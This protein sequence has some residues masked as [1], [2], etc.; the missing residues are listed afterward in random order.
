MRVSMGFAVPEDKI[1]EVEANLREHGYILEPD[2]VWRHPDRRDD[3]IP[4]F[5]QLVK[6][7]CDG[8]CHDDIIDEAEAADL[9]REQEEF[10]GN[11][12]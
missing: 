4:E 11:R 6:A 3:A 10:Y 7:M 5:G 9:V 2:G 8:E 1:H 12:D